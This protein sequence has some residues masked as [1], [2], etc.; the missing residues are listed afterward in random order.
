[1][2]LARPRISG[3]DR[4]HRNAE[5]ERRRLPVDIAALTEGLDEGRIAGE[6]RH[7]PQLDLRVVGHQEHHI[8]A[9]GTNPR[10][11]S[12]PRSVRIGMFWRLGSEEL[13][14]PVA[15]PD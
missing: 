9:A 11:I 1:M 10:R 12:S 13:S 6:V 8:P 15:A 4:L 7:E 5:D 3:G 2:V 14:R